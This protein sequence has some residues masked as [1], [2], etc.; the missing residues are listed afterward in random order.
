MHEAVSNLIGWLS[1]SWHPFGCGLLLVKWAVLCTHL[2]G[3]LDLMPVLGCHRRCHADK[4]PKLLV[5]GLCLPSSNALHLGLGPLHA[6][7][8][9]TGTA[10]GGLIN[11]CRSADDPNPCLQAR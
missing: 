4:T 6:L 8:P 11:S 3:M 9:C 5:Q 1:S 2:Q 10:T 7:S